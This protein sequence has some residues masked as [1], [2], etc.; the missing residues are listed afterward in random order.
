MF[1]P[2]FVTGS[3]I[4]RFGHLPGIAAGLALPAR[5]GG[6]APAAVDLHHSYVALSALG[7]GWTFPVVGAT[8]LLAT[9]H[10]AAE[11][12]KVRG[13]ND[14]LVFGLVAAASFGPGALRDRYG[15][16]AVQ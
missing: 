3:I 9:A 4:A 13:L 8:S 10:R 12:A 15:W 7:V 2:S 16:H 1:A 14:F 6:S 11:Q 5:C